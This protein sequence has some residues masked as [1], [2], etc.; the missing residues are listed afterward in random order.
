MIEACRAATSI[1]LATV[2][3]MAGCLSPV[4]EQ[5]SDQSLDEAPSEEPDGSQTDRSANSPSSNGSEETTAPANETQPEDGD[6]GSEDEPEPRT[7]GH[8]R[9]ETRITGETTRV[10]ALE[11]NHIENL[12]ALGIQPVGVAEKDG[13]QKWVGAGELDDEVVDVGSRAEPSLETIADLNPDLIL[14]IEFRHDEIYSD[15]ASIAPTLLFDGF[16]AQ[17]EDDDQHDRMVSILERTAK[18]T[19]HEDEGQATL[20]EMRATF[21]D[22]RQRLE[23]AG[24][25]EREVLLTQV[26]TYN[27]QPLA[28]T[29]L[30]SSIPANVAERIGLANA[31]TKTDCSTGYGYC[32]VSKE[33]FADVQHADFFYQ[34]QPDDDPVQDDWDDDPVWN[35]YEF[36]REDRV[37]PLGA[38]AWMFGGPL[39]TQQLAER[40]TDHLTT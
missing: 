40:I 39:V 7:V 16:P 24:Q 25:T 26:F 29:F 23:E 36:V 17:D 12:L 13:Y 4:G 28:R 33:G 11:Y 5:A 30:N 21:D 31:W 32:D 19:A 6:A 34:A 14:A 2:L 22:A 15:L 9:G 18:A 27:D 38:D 8:A 3:L 10:V 20:A 37:Y 1:V 35:S